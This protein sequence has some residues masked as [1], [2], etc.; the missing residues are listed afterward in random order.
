MWNSY[1]ESI[2]KRICIVVIDDGSATPLRFN[3]HP[4]FAFVHLR[5]TEDIPWNQPGAKNLAMHFVPTEWAFLTDADHMLPTEAA[6]VL[7][8]YSPAAGTVY[9]PARLRNG[10]PCHPHP[11]SFLINKKDFF[12]INGYDEDFC[13]N[14]GH[15]DHF[16]VAKAQQRFELKPLDEVVLHNDQDNSTPDVERNHKKNKKLLKKKKK[17]LE[18]G[19]YAAPPMVRFNWEIVTI[20]PPLL[21]S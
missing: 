14:Y 7:L 9:M 1:P 13:G 15:D 11:N 4:G 5:A 2:R 3:P 16:F 17:L 21:R 12:S 18:R 6:A 20:N 19:R 10:Q 8:G